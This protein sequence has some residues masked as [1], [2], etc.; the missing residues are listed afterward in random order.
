MIVRVKLPGPPV[1]IAGRKFAHGGKGQRLNDA[2]LE[3]LI[4]TKDGAVKTG[5]VLF[6]TGRL[7]LAHDDGKALTVEEFQTL[8]PDDEPSRLEAGL[9]SEAPQG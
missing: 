2:D 5:R 4:A 8:F 7:E 6:L 9:T 3:A 1:Y